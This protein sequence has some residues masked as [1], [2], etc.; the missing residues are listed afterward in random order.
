[1]AGYVSDKAESSSTTI[2]L[3]SKTSNNYKEIEVLTSPSVVIEEYEDFIESSDFLGDNS[4][5]VRY[6]DSPDENEIFNIASPEVEEEIA[7]KFDSPVD[8]N[9]SDA[10]DYN[11]L[12][13]QN[14]L[15]LAMEDLKQSNYSDFVQSLPNQIRALFIYQMNFVKKMQVPRSADLIKNL[16]TQAAININYFKL[17][18]IEIHDGYEMTEN[19]EKK[20]NEPK[21]KLL[22]ESDL[23]NIKVP[24]MCRLTRFY[25]NNLKL[26]R[27][28]L[29]FPFEGQI[30][31]IQ[32]NNYKPVKPYFRNTEQ[33]TKRLAVQHI[34]PRNYDITKCTSNIINYS[35]EN[36]PTYTK[37]NDGSGGIVSTP[38][39][40][41]PSSVAPTSTATVTSTGGGY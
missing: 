30:F 23:D 32:P 17:A 28:M 26:E 27:D 7:E 31:F 34:S 5:F 29:S 16:K 18:R 4:L 14:L 39:P 6:A 8:L 24:T 2:T 36:A 12:F 21:F 33:Q 15:N 25:N 22:K 40:Q 35:N 20:I 1:M 38:G 10:N 11:L 13:E 41:A 37:P 19:G 9:I 3:A